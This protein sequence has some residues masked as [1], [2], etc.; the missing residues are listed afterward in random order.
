MKNIVLLGSTGSIGTQT[1]DVVRSYKE[2]LHVVA[3]AA[4]S[5]VEKMEQQIREFSPSYAVMWS[6]E[7][8]KDLKQRVSDL[9]VQVLTGMDGLLAISVLPEAARPAISIAAPAL[10][11]SALTGAP[12]SCSTP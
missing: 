6:E 11:S 3:L 8:A 5:S 9:Q 7:A 10:R 2:D 4:G 1:L 12:L